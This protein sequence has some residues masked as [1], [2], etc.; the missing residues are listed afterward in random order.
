MRQIKFRGLR[1]DNKK[2]VYGGLILPPSSPRRFIGYIELMDEG[3]EV[4]IVHYDEVDPA[5]V[6]Q[7]IDKP[8]KNGL[9]QIYES[10][11][12]G[13]DGLVKGNQ[14]DDPDLFKEKTN[15]LIQ[16]FGTADWQATEKEGLERG[17]KYA[18]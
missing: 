14:Y 10:D 11:I 8:D 7:C 12:I 13:P 15:L 6:G 5:T 18:E 9:T 17:C 16:G 2:W 3:G 1:L 4:V